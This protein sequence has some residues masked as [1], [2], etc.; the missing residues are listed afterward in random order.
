MSRLAAQLVLNEL[1]R[2]ADEFYKEVDNGN[3][4]EKKEI[5]KSIIVMK[6]LQ[7]NMQSQDILEKG[8]EEKQKRVSRKMTKENV[9]ALIKTTK[10][11]VEIESEVL[12][13]LEE[14]DT[15]ME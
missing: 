12:Q 10:A 8:I 2:A 7:L 13:L 14:L 3:E 5:R 6:L 1:L 11:L 4:E 9:Q 15:L